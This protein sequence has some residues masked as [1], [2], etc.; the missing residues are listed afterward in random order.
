MSAGRHAGDARLKQCRSP[1]KNLDP[2]EDPSN[3]P[4][5]FLASNGHFVAT[6]SSVKG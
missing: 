5:L 4:P 2:F 6:V 3:I 1:L